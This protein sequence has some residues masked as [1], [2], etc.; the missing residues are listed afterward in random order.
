MSLTQLEKLVSKVKTLEVMVIMGM[1]VVMEMERV[2]MVLLQPL[3]VFRN[4][5]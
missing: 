1:I 5:G 2:E 4:T 3:L